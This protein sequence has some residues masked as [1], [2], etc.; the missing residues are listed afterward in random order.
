MLSCVIP[1]SSHRGTQTSR[2]IYAFKTRR[3]PGAS[4]R[5]TGIWTPCCDRPIPGQVAIRLH[6]RRYE[7][8]VSYPFRPFLSRA[9][10]ASLCAAF[11]SPQRTHVMY[12]LVCRLIMLCLCVITNTTYRK[13]PKHGGR[14]DLNNVFL[15][16]F[17]S[18][19]P[20]CL[21]IT[22]TLMSSCE[23]VDQ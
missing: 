15:C 21:S 16:L 11:L 12:C 19:A 3:V 8:H 18:W 17:E 2:V 13:H 4:H 1:L 10:S 20:S 14:V 7:L 23:V 9:F 22:P 5:I 6:S